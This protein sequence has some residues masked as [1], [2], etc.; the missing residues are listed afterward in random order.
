MA[1]VDRL[2][3]AAHSTD[4]GFRSRTARN[5]AIGNHTRRC[6]PIRR[7]IHM[8][9]LERVRTGRTSRN[10]RLAVSSDG[11]GDSL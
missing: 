10:K 7:P 11:D 2:V 6:R 9:I 8:G 4:Y 3:A 5:V 1:D